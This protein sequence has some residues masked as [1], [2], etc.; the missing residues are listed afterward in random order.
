M[1]SLIYWILIIIGAILVL[2]SALTFKRKGEAELSANV[3]ETPLF[4][5]GVVMIVLGFVLML[6]SI[7]I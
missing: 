1:L 3:T 6:V 7:I 4:K 2:A 5:I